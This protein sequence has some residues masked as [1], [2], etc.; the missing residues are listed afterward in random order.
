MC[1]ILV[2]LYFLLVLHFSHCRI[3]FDETVSVLEIYTK[4]IDI[5]DLSIIKVMSKVLLYIERPSY[6]CFR[7]ELFI[8]V[9]ALK[10]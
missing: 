5:Y 9:I 1:A 10:R 3:Q 8:A 2:T 4:M 6:T 7:V